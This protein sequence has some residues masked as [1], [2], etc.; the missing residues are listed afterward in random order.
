M[1]QE[2]VY[3]FTF[4]NTYFSIICHCKC[5]TCKNINMNTFQHF[6]GW[7]IKL[8]IISNQSNMIDRFLCCKLNTDIVIN[9][10]SWRVSTF[11]SVLWLDRHKT[12]PSGNNIVLTNFIINILWGVFRE[13]FAILGRCFFF[14]FLYLSSELF[15]IPLEY[16]WGFFLPRVFFAPSLFLTPV[17]WNH[18]KISSIKKPESHRPGSRTVFGI[19]EVTPMKQ[20]MLSW[21]LFPSEDR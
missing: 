19:N 21:R 18:Q 16:R 3:I 2:N 9:S 4:I 6:H 8:I 20:A 1:D 5:K 14:S 12:D 11:L 13:C 17:S 7:L 15:Q 10:C